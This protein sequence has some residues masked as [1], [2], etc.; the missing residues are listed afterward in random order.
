VTRTLTVLRQ[1]VDVTTTTVFDD[2]LPGGQA[3]LAVGDIVE[4]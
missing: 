2:A 4:V 1:A 3:A